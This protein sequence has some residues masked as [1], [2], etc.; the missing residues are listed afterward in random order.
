MNKTIQIPD[1]YKAFQNLKSGELIL[2]VRSPEE[3]ATGH[4]PGSRNIPHDQVA[5]HKDALSKF[6]NVYVYCRSGGRVQMCCAELQ[7]LGLTNISAV[8]G[9]GMPDWIA[10][11]YP[12]K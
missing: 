9:C 5:S 8:V 6:E 7:N 1:L 4:V 12:S 2:D 11:G 10:A 3:Y